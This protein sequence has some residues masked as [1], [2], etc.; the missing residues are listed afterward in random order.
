MSNILKDA[1]QPL[2]FLVVENNPDD[3]YLIA[4]AFKKVP[5]CGTLSLTRNTSEA[6][7]YLKGAGMYSDRARFPF[8]SAVLSDFSMQGETGVQLLKWIQN[9]PGLVRIPFILLTGSAS[10][11]DREEAA[12]FGAV[13]V[14]SKS[15]D[16]EKMKQTLED[17]AQWLCSD[18][19]RS[20]PYPKIGETQFQQIASPQKANS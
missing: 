20:G 1:K 12:K 5:Q 2:H 19:V 18:K 3:A 11:K 7:A 10:Q 14:V 4:R 6:K 15:S 9:D 8:P 16:T 13:R 17:L